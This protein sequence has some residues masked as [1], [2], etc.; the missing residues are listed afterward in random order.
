MTYTVPR[1]GPN[2]ALDGWLIDNVTLPQA[3]HA[4]E[5]LAGAPESSLVV[6]P[7]MSHLRLLRHDQA[8]REA[9]EGATLRLADGMPLVW[10]SRIVRA[11]LPERIAGADL[12]P[13]ICAR[14]ASVGGHVIYIG[15]DTEEINRRAIAR[16]KSDFP[17]LTI[18]GRSPSMRFT[19]DP[20]ET[21]R[22]VKFINDVT[23]PDQ[24]TAVLVCAGAPRSEIWAW[25][26]MAKDGNQEGIRHGVILPL[27]AAIDFAA[28]ERKRAS[29][30]MRHS[31]FEWLS[32]LAQEPLRLGPRYTRDALHVGRLIS[33]AMRVRYGI[34]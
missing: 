18:S 22:L 7:N 27:G 25:Q 14:L 31:G 10:A 5:S 8:F 4:I 30:R 23:E 2:V 26:N 12:E 21:S 3:V 20:G 33:H 15:G 19:R 29:E 34:V 17:S 16:R 24:P 32:R 13:A 28:G 1:I 9:Y 6:T 11:P